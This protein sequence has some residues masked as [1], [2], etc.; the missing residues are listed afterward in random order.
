MPHNSHAIHVME[1]API[2]GASHEHLHGV[3]SL[4]LQVHCHRTA[5]SAGVVSCHLPALFQNFQQ[6]LAILSATRFLKMHATLFT[7]VLVV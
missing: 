6:A 3:Y 2:I 7:A 5:S 4:A 1:V